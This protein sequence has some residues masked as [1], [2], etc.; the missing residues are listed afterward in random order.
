[1]KWIIYDFKSTMKVAE[2][3]EVVDKEIICTGKCKYSEEKVEYV[4][5]VAINGEY[6]IEDDGLP[7]SDTASTDDVLNALLGVT[8]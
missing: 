3:E 2:N 8:V 5:S 7:E 6:D 4:K 1:M